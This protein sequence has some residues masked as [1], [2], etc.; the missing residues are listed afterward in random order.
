MSLLEWI[1]EVNLAYRHRPAEAAKVFE[2]YSPHARIENLGTATVNYAMPV[3]GAL[4]F[5]SGRGQ[6]DPSVPFFPPTPSKT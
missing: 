1:Y 5:T 2:V 3:Q 4:D 6:A